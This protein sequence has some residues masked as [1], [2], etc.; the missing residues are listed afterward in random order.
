MTGAMA[1]STVLRLSERTSSLRVVT[2]TVN[3]VCNLRCPHCYLQYN[4][5]SEFISDDLVELILAADFMH[6]A[7]VGKEP[8]VNRRSGE[9][10]LRIIERARAAG[11]TV[12]L[13][14]NGLGLH[15]LPVDALPELEW[16]DVSLDGGPTTY[17]AYRHASYARLRSN[18]DRLLSFG[19][20]KINALNTLSSGNVHAIDDMI[21]AG[22]D[23][24]FTRI[25]FSPFVETSN[26]GINTVAALSFDELCSALTRSNRFARSDRAILLLGAHAYERQGYSANQIQTRLEACDLWK[27][28]VFIQ[29]DPLQ[30]GFVRVTYDGLV[31][32]PYESLNT[33]RY[34]YLGRTLH[35]PMDLPRLFSTFATNALAS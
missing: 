1:G 30:L 28:T 19:Y 31:L 14:T 10:C 3:N 17:S 35:G 29:D 32:T 11:K 22:D 33:A 15:H 13:I 6:L 27:S 8:L 20:E 34:R 26:D 2:L 12:S 23:V 24:P 7:I 5:D 9:G 18:L 16:I 4:G 25:I 21:A